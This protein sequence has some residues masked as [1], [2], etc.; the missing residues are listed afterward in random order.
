ML[1][2]SPQCNGQA[3]ASNK[4]ILDGIR[5]RLDKAKG[6]WVEELS[7]VLWAYRT[8]SW[9]STSET[10]FSLA[11]GTEAVIPLETGI[12]TIR[13]SLVE[14]GGNHAALEVQQDLA[15]ERRERALVRL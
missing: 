15:E 2:R 6:R 11:Y 12:P 14:Q 8:T 9:R 10:P 5:K 13:T 4:T 7:L 1:F 3:E